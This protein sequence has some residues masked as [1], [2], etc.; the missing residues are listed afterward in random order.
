MGRE[1]AVNHFSLRP[2][3]AVTLNL[4]GRGPMSHVPIINNNR[5]HEGFNGNMSHKHSP[6]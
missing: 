1:E 4:V 5:P 6:I 3:K 2:S